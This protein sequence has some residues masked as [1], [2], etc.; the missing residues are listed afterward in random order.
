MKIID[1]NLPE[2]VAFRHPE[3]TCEQ[4]YKAFNL[5]RGR[6]D[7]FY[8]MEPDALPVRSRW[9]ARLVVEV[10]HPPCTSF[11]IRGSVSHCDGNY[12]E[13]R[14]RLDLHING[15]A[16]YCVG[17]HALGALFERVKRFYPSYFEAPVFS[18]G[19]ALGGF[20]HSIYQFLHHR[21]NF[22]YARTVLHLYQYTDVLYNLCEEAYDPD[23]LRVEEP[24]VQIVHSKAPWF[25]ETE[26]QVRPSFLHADRGYVA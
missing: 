16:L 3:G 5:L 2:A 19:C 9:L 14:N 11:W 1:A 18:A 12:G 15:G 4:F 7:Y 24:N 6:V 8:L 20:D 25:D 10:Q 22:N 21:S 17:D 26:R 13:M 23:R